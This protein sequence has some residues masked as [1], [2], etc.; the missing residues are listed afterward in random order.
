M[1]EVEPGEPNG[2]AS[3]AGT[4]KLQPILAPAMGIQVMAFH[5]LP[6]A[7]NVRFL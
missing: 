5:G 1:I 2:P 4:Q 7:L 3:E 6:M